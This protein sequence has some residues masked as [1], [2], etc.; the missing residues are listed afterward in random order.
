MTDDAPTQAVTTAP[1]TGSALVKVVAERRLN[2]YATSVRD[3]ARGV[4]EAASGPVP[5]RDIVAAV[6]SFGIAI[7]GQNELNAVSALLSR[8]PDFKNADRTGW[9]LA[10]PVHHENGALNGKPASAPEVEGI[11]V[12]SNENRAMP[13][14]LLG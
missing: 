7:S 9:V 4:I 13:S 6:K 8:S 3:V 12:P 1:A 14:G 11:A 5:T 10:N 2:A